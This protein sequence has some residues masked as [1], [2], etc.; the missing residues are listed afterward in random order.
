MGLKVMLKMHVDLTNDDGHWR[1]DIGLGMD[2]SAWTLWFKSYENA[3]FH[4]A[5]MA[6]E[7]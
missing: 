2:E 1:G 3:L 4:Y 6:E 5:R 7:L